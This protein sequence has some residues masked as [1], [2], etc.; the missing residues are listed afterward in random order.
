MRTGFFELEFA[1]AQ[2]NPGCG[3]RV[4]PNFAAF[5]PEIRRA[6]LSRKRE[7]FTAAHLAKGGRKT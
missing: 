1:R 6:T 5:Y 7:L 2:A 3:C 4:G